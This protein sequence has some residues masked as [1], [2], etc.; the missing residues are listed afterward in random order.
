MT[1]APHRLVNGGSLEKPPTLLAARQR[2]V[3]VETREVVIQ[4]Q[5]ESRELLRASLK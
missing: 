5:S 1:K 4:T 3:L 2:R